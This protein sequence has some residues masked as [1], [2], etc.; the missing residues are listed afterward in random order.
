MCPHFKSRSSDLNGQK[1]DQRFSQLMTGLAPRNDLT[2][3]HLVSYHS[4][5][6][7]E[8]SSIHQTCQVRDNL[9]RPS[10]RSAQRLSALVRDADVTVRQ[11]QPN[12]R[13]AC[14]IRCVHA[15]AK[16]DRMRRSETRQH[17]VLNPRTWPSAHRQPALTER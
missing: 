9:K 8:P 6:V 16:S 3:D 1:N 15:S 2:L 13:P 14:S 11:P 5:E 7:L 17:P 12:A 4:R 10:V